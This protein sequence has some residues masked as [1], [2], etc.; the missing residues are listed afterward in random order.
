MTKISCKQDNKSSSKDVKGK[1]NNLFNMHS[2]LRAV[3][4]TSALL[5]PITTVINSVIKA[6]LS[7]TVGNLA[8]T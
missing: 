5:V 7:E 1:G 8:L 2:F 6:G 3:V 4:S